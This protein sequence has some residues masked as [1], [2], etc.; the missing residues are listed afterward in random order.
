MGVDVLRSLHGT[1]KTLGAD[2]GLL[3]S[4]GGFKETVRSKAKS[5]FFTIRLW[6]SG[7]LIQSILS[8][9]DKLPKDLRATLPLKRIWILVE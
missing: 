9:Y 7:D 2:Q 4:W 3:V 1:M 8:N 5:Q 6:N